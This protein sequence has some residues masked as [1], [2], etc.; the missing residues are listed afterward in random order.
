MIGIIPNIHKVEALAFTSELVEK[1][2]QNN[3]KFSIWN[4]AQHLVDVD[5]KTV[6][7]N[8]D[9]LCNNNEIILSIGGDG[10][11][12]NSSYYAVKY[13]KPIHGVNFGKLG[14]LTEN[15]GQNL[16]DLIHILTNKEFFIEN[17]II[18]SGRITGE[19]DLQ[20]MGVND[21]VVDRGT[22]TKAIIIS[23]Y[24]DDEYVNT[25]TADGIVVATPTGS[26]GYSLSAGGSVITPLSNVFIVSPIA[27]HSMTVRPIIINDSQSVTLKVQTRG[28]SIRVTC[29]GQRDYMC[30]SQAEVVIS[31]S[32]KTL[33]LIKTSQTSYFELIREKLFWGY[34]FRNKE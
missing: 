30:G 28:E 23:I 29:D 33:K 16:N 8:E 14:F 11:L 13:G 9:N 2:A 4:G 1:L 21:I 6:F 19:T 24:V 10:T 15:S 32:N 31:K 22:C 34:D 26:T 18:L 20:L 25:I 12:L 3:V 5:K 17:R 7:E 27:P